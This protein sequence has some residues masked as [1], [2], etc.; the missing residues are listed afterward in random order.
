MT[1]RVTEGYI[2]KDFGLIDK[3]NDKVMK[4]F[5][6]AAKKAENPKN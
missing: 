2:T 5:R 4:L 1:R 6:K 3:A